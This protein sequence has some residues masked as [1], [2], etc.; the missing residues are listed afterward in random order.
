MGCCEGSCSCGKGNQSP[1]QKNIHLVQMSASQEMRATHDWIKGL[2][3]LWVD[4]EVVEIRFKNSRKAFYRNRTGF[5]LKKDE[6]IVV[7]VEAGHD[8]GTVSL[9]GSLAEKQFEQKSTRG[10]EATA[11]EKKRNKT[12]LKKVYRKA[13]QVDLEKWLDAKKRERAVLLH[14]RR[15]A[16][17]LGL[18]V[19][20]SDVEF[21]GDGGKV[22]V[23]YTADGKVD[24][25]QLIGK[26][27]LAFQVKIEMKQ[28][29]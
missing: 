23:Y 25:R 1:E 4:E 13:T 19:S 28:V 26:Y 16:G 24:F 18:E 3:C 5:S 22:T 11:E 9:A 27:T 8:L 15:L 20:I 2:G 10:T 7:E 29:T 14:S 6:R 12:G 17:D 21:Q